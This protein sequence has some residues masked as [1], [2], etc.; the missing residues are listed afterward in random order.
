MWTSGMRW[1][2]SWRLIGCNFS[3]VLISCPITPFS[4]CNCAESVLALGERGRPTWGWTSVPQNQQSRVYGGESV[5]EDSWL[6][7]SGVLPLL[8]SPRLP[9][10]CPTL[11][12][13]LIGFFNFCPWLLII[14]LWSQRLPQLWRWAHVINPV[15]E[16][17]RCDCSSVAVALSPCQP[18]TC[19][20][21][22]DV[23]PWGFRLRY[24][25]HETPSKNAKSL[26]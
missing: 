16:S 12:P 3:P 6:A 26:H 2:L 11:C 22:Q 17:V 14:N 9:D 21:T 20:C 19:V 25:T 24:L 5:R 10:G 4:P 23:Y 18:L 7:S 13:P 15:I 8:A 1:K